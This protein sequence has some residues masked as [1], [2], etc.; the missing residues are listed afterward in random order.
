M[1]RC[2]VPSP[3]SFTVSRFRGIFLFKFSA[4]KQ[5]TLSVPQRCVLILSH[6][7]SLQVPILPYCDGVGGLGNSQYREPDLVDPIVHNVR[8]IH[9]GRLGNAFPKIDGTSYRVEM[10]LEINGLKQARKSGVDRD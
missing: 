9:T 4:I 2:M 8:D 3:L 6:V 7:S 5:V 10:F 1:P